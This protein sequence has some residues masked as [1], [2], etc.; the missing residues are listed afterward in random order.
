MFTKED[1]LEEKINRV[2]MSK[3]QKVKAEYKEWEERAKGKKKQHQ[4]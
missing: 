3:N 2:L 4:F 1:T